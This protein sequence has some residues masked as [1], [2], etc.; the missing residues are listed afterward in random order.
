MNQTQ[1]IYIHNSSFLAQSLKPAPK[2]LLKTLYWH[3]TFI[4]FFFNRFPG[5]APQ[6]EMTKSLCDMECNLAFSLK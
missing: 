1:E 5:H 2:A 6:L 3:Y 4:F